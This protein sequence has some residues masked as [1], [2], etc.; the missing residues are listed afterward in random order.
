MFEA[1]LYERASRT[2]SESPAGIGD[3]RQQPKNLGST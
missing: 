1:G 3:G 2:D